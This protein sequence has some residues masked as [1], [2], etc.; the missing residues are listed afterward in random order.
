MLLFGTL[1]GALA[2]QL[3]SL[4]GGKDTRPMDDEKFW[5]AAMLQ[6]GGLGIWGDFVLA[7]QNRFGGGLIS[8]LA[9]PAAGR[10]EKLLGLGPG[11]L[12][13][14]IEGNRTNAGRELTNAIRDW[15]PA[16]GT[17]WFTK[18]AWQRLFIDQLQKT[19]DPEAYRSFQRQV[20]NARRDYRQTYWW[21]PGTTAPQ[22]APDFADAVGQR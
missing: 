16:V 21:A 14:A 5:F 13:E 15:T 7:E 8:T 3:K 19:L 2:M 12:R 10:L 1:G 17:L 6:G 11:N 9:G 20:Q 4:S 18:L 22:R